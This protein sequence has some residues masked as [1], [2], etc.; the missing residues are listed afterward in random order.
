MAC[1][2]IDLV[3][4]LPVAPTFTLPGCLFLEIAQWGS[5][6]TACCRDEIVCPINGPI[7]PSV[8]LIGILFC[9]PC[10][11]FRVASLSLLLGVSVSLY[12]LLL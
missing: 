9:L 6:N 3:L 11:M 8:L 12:S 10:L 7:Y 5:K 4:P 2:N 1:V